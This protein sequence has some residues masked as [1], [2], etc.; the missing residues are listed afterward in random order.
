[1]RINHQQRMMPAGVR[2]RDRDSIRSRIRLRLLLR[3]RLHHGLLPIK[4]LKL[5]QFD[6]FDIAADTPSV[7]LNAIHGSNRW[8]TRGFTSGCFAR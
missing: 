5:I 8:I 4:R 6:L 3:A 1:M 7:K 2:R